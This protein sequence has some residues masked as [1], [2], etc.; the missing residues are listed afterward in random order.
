MES[1][2]RSLLNSYRIAD[3]TWRDCTVTCEALQCLPEMSVLL[4]THTV[5]AIMWYCNKFCWQAF[6]SRA[7]YLSG[8]FLTE[9]LIFLSVCL[10]GLLASGD[11]WLTSSIFSNEIEQYAVNVCV[12]GKDSKSHSENHGLDGA[13][14]PSPQKCL[15]WRS[16]EKAWA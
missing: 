8:W 5:K 12:H 4:A 6:L 9:K 13:L 16:F 11:L 14:S 7:T 1:L 2:E 15:W 3:G 10:N